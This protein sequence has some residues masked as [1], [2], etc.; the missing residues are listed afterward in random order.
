MMLKTK[1]IIISL[2]ILSTVSA[3][4][5]FFPILGGQR[6]GTS[7][8]TFLKIGVGAR[9]VGMGEAVVALNQDATALYY[10]PA[11]V[12]QLEKTQLSAARV[13]WPAEIYYD[14]IGI[15]RRISGRH[16]LGFSAGILHMAPMEETTEFM[17][18]GTGNYF[19]YQDRFLALTYSTALSDRFSFGVTIKHVSENLAGI[20]METVMMDL[21]TFYWTGYKTLRFSAVLSH[22]GPNAKPN[23]TYIK[24]VLDHETGEETEIKSEYE[25][26]SP[27][28]VFRV[29]TAMEIIELKD[30]R[31]TLAVQL[32]HPVD[33][34]ENIS[35]GTEY[36]F[37]NTLALRGGYKLNKEEENFS[38]G[39][40]LYLPAGPFKLRADYS[41]T[42][43]SHLTN[44]SRVS[45]GLLF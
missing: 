36:W 2:M 4:Q 20:L 25:S 37:L 43:Q 8:F 24:R 6:A 39:I 35:L 22:F 7:V 3:Q 13:Q 31:L 29:G 41:Y 16:F 26:F 44:P 15:S 42:N 33:N 34:A 17:P 30:H 38:M 10:N 32:N 27:P 28:T 5:N 19:I 18:H 40:G 21:G 45:I 14:F 12:A 1:I 9:A 23:G 11:A